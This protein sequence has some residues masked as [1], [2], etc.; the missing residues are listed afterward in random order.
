[1]TPWGQLVHVR[2]AVD[3]ER[4]FVVDSW[5]RSW[6]PNTRPRMNCGQAA[7]IVVAHLA[8]CERVLVAE[9][10]GVAGTRGPKICCWAALLAPRVLGYVYVLHD[11]RRRGI[12]TRLLADLGIMPRGGR[13][14]YEF[15][16]QRMRRLC[17]PDPRRPDR[18]PW[19]GV[20]NGKDRR[21][22]H[23]AR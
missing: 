12:A 6:T 11:Y 19:T 10:P 18:E 16:T 13:W 14:W 22:N 20:P 8:R 15:G 1:M 5:V 3:D 23:Q 4:A 21:S 2:A 17:R 9:V 7:P